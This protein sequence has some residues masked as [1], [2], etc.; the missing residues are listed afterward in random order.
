MP[1]QVDDHLALLIEV[2]IVR[3]PSAHAGELAGVFDGP[4]LGHGGSVTWPGRRWRSKE[5]WGSGREPPGV[6][7]GVLWPRAA[8]F[9]AGGQG[10]GGSLPSAPLKMEYP[11]REDVVQKRGSAQAVI[12]VV[13]EAGLVVVDLPGGVYAFDLLQFVQTHPS[14]EAEA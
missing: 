11:A 8:S 2:Q 1:W 4:V 9:Q 13:P 12:D 14:P 10:G 6:A 3:P 7:D 5:K